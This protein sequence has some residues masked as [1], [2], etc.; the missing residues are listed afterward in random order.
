MKKALSKDWDFLVFMSPNGVRSASNLVNL[1]KF[2]IIA[3]GNRTKT[4]LEEY[5]CKEV[6]V[7]EKQSSAGV[8]EFLKEKDGSALA[9]K[10]I[11]GAEN[12]IAYSIKPKKLLPIIDEYLGKKSDFTLL[13]SAGLLELLLQNAEEKGK[14]ARLMEKLNDSF[15]ISIGRKTTE[16]ALPNNIWV[17]Y[18][19]SK[20][21]LE[22]LFQRSLQ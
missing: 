1:T 19:L 22:S 12:V 5:G 2:K 17:N 3:V 14:E 10:E 11:K 20:P 9:K 7:P 16:F 4:K 15:V 18:E 8:E 13:T 21:S 6:I